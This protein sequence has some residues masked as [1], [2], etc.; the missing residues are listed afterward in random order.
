MDIL[1]V[2]HGS[3]DETSSETTSEPG[4]S[5]HGVRQINV[6]VEAIK[7]RP[8]SVDCYLTSLSPHALKTAEQLHQR[9]SPEF[10]PPIQLASLTPRTG[11]PGGIDELV[12][13]ALVECPDLSARSGVVVV[14]HEG[15][16]SDLV[17]ELTGERS[18]PLGHGEAVCIRGKSL[19]DLV[20]GRGT[21][22][23]RFPTFDHQEVS[24][25]SKVQSKMT[26]ST[27]LAG[28]VFTAL[29]SLLLLKQPNWSWDQIVGTICL[30]ASLA[31]FVAC[32][33]IYDQLGMPSGYWTDAQPPR[34][35]RRFYVWQE[36]ERE[37]QWERD[38]KAKGDV[39][40]DERQAASLQNGPR[41][42]LMI[43]TSRLLFTPAATLALLGFVMLLFGTGD[44]RILVGGCTG[45]VLAGAYA[46]SKRP[47]LG[48]D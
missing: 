45:L 22:H 14:G 1:L 33:Y 13:Q 39:D 44:W 15:R 20:A 23:F 16:L 27:F 34:A 8:T 28:F 9:L 24:L 4:L 48:A 40:A 41:Y 2:R 42:N 25:R 38:A 47:N 5:R 17:T 26:V 46:A 29:S 37:R 10:H 7:R 35:W 19:D 6:L 43:S 11:N 18:R 36:R 32:V 31:L 3:K 30:S 12:K 21:I